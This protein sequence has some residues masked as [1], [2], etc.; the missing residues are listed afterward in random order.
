MRRNVFKLEKVLH[1]RR[2][3][4][5]LRKM[6]FAAAKREYEIAEDRLRREEESIDR[7]AL[8]FM[9]RQTEGIS[10]LELQLYSDFLV[11]KRESIRL[12]REHVT[13]LDQKMSEKKEDLIEAA[14][15]KKIMEELKKKKVAAHERSLAEKE[16][17]FLDEI[18][19]QG[20]GVR[21]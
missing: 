12:Q 11:Q 13:T 10:A 21:A 6:E 4:E 15:D 7:L 3:T 8:E 5:R 20:R 2:E 17:A 1:F 19:L 9:S 16:Q 14:T 18:A